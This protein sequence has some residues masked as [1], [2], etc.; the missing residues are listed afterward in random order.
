M[1][2]IKHCGDHN[3]KARHVNLGLVPGEAL[4]VDQL[5]NWGYYQTHLCTE[6]GGMTVEEPDNEEVDRGE[7]RLINTMVDLGL[8]DQKKADEILGN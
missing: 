3:G 2:T 1:E 4:G 6:C 8:I 5:D 7:E